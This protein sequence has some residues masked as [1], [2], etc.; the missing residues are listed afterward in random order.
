MLSKP[1][2]AWCAAGIRLAS[3]SL[4]SQDAVFCSP[5]VHAPQ[6]GRK[7]AALYLAAAFQMFFNPAASINVIHQRVAAMLQPDR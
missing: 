6:R 5:V 1:G 3:T 7:L 4:L 2:I